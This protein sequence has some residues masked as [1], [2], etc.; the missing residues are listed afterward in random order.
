MR[1]YLVTRN[2]YSDLNGAKFA[3]GMTVPA[4]TIEGAFA[5]ESV[6]AWVA[7]GFLVSINDEP[8]PKR[9]KAVSE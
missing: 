7:R 4:A 6:A 5:A 2:L 3:A 8:K 1:Q 9:K